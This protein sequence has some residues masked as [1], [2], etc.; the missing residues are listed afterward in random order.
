MFWLSD[1][2]ELIREFAQFL[3]GLESSLLEILLFAAF[4]SGALQ[5]LRRL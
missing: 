3:R 5:F 4:V 1:A 2:A